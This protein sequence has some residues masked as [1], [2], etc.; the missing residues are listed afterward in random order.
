LLK[1]L[2]IHFEIHKEQISPYNQEFVDM[3][4]KSAQVDGGKVID[5]KSLFYLL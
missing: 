2:G 5:P 4:K 1:E 3:V